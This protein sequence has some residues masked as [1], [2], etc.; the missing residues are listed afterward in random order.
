M[1][2]ETQQ[3]V[4][5]IRYLA[6]LYSG[7][8]VAA[9]TLEKIGSLEAH[10][11]SLETKA[12]DLEA[13]L[14]KWYD[15]KIEV[16]KSIDALHRSYDETVARQDDEL[17]ARHQKAEEEAKAIVAASVAS[18]D[19]F[20]AL[21]KESVEKELAA[22]REHM[23][24]LASQLEA[25]SARTEQAKADTAVAEERK[26]VAEKGLEEVTKSINQLMGGVR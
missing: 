8:I 5:S 13:D 6:N 18:A 21:A 4:E 17:L 26:A 20:E 14:K 22:H 3:A 9:N 16:A 10:V 11:A 2:Q 23:V 12:H 19:A 7:M 1:S 24:A 15:E 25:L